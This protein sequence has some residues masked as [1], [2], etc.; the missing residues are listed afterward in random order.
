[1]HPCGAGL[2][3]CRNHCNYGSKNYGHESLLSKFQKKRPVHVLCHVLV[4]DYYEG[5]TVSIYLGLLRLVSPDF[6]DER[7]PLCTLTL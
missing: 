6:H 7:E 3:K 1:M 4:P 2:S 5:M